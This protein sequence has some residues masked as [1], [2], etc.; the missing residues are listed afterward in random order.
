MSDYLTLIKQKEEEMH[1][2]DARMQQDADILYLKKY[3]MR[4]SQGQRVPDVI[5][6]TLNRPAIFAASV[7][8]AL[9][10]ASQQTI[11]ESENESIDTSK[12][13]EFQ[14]A[15]FNAADAR[16]RR[17]AGRA[18]LN[19]FAD[20]QLCIRGRTARRVLFRMEGGVLVPD[21]VPWDGRYVR[22]DEDTEGLAWASYQT[23]RSKANIEGEYGIT[24]K[25]REGGVLDVWDRDHNEVFIDGRKELEQPHPYGEVPVVVQVVSL[26]YGASLMDGVASLGYGGGSQVP[27]RLAREGESIFFLIRDIIPELNR[28][29][30]ILQTLNLKAVKPPAVETRKGG[31]DSGEYEERMG[32]GSITGMD[33]GESINLVNYG[34]AKRAAEMLYNIM[35]KAMQAGSITDVDLGNLQFPLSAVALVEL[36]EGRDQVYL[37]RLQ[38]KAMLNQATAEM[39]TRQVL[40]IGGTIELGTP[41]HKRRFSTKKLM[42]EYETTYKYFTKSPKI[43]IARMSMA[44]AAERYFDTETIL[45]DVLMVEDWKGTLQKK[46]YYMAE[47]VDPLILRHRI[48]MSMVE[49]AEEGDENAAKEAEIMAASMGMSLSQIKAGVMQPEAPPQPKESA[50]VVPLLGGGGQVGGLPTSAQKA[51]QLVRT[52]AREE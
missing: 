46:Y 14:V 48:I 6:I 12:I 1:D 49:L 38:A 25:G 10:G 8:S 44:Q 23:Y 11:V 2:L 35:E 13:E 50:P 47:Q 7:I 15:A 31:G 37:P 17:Q 41:G 26:G 3:V 52:P 9:S 4:D 21:I 32:I 42:G 20:I 30:T 5:N 19:P 27:T 34:D 51:S 18:T 33:V 22:F 39:F 43:D 29:A 28:L 36:G 40:Q 45:K 24:V 16:L